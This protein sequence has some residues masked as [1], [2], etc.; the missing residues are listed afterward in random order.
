[1]SI[2]AL[3]WTRPTVDQN[4]TIRLTKRR[5][6]EGKLPASDV[7]VEFANSIRPVCETI[8]SSKVEGVLFC[9]AGRI[10]FN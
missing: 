9:P 8:T 10:T 1:M 6:C 5:F 4:A 7:P 3:Q 2:I